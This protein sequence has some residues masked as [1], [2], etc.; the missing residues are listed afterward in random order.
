MAGATYQLLSNSL[1]IRLSPEGRRSTFTIP[2]GDTVMVVDGLIAGRRLVEVEW[3][4]ELVLVFADDLQ[5][6]EASYFSVDRIRKRGTNENNSFSEAQGREQALIEHSIELAVSNEDLERFSFMAAHDL[7]APLRS[8][9]IAAQLLLRKNSGILDAQSLAWL[10]E[11]T[12]GSDRMNELIKDLLDFAVSNNEAEV[13]HVSVFEVV[14]LALLQLK[15]A[16]E[17]AQAK[18]TIDALPPLVLANEGQLTALFQNLIG[19]AIKYRRDCHPEIHISAA[20]DHE[21]VF[22][23]AD[24]GIGID[25][26]FSQTIFSPFQRLHAAAQYE[27]TGIGL[28]ICK[29]VVEKYGGRIW[30]ESQLEQ[31]STFRFTI[32][33]AQVADVTV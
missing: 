7:R 11:I 31:G 28:A 12:S 30:V 16:V 33:N 14:T 5:H 18:I 15:E 21:T 1:A 17:D 3:K 2:A 20:R 26:R 25:P 29:R 9:K 32:P 24:N 4:S 22:S 19:N 8:I 10:S 27:G 13:T 23:V 6:S